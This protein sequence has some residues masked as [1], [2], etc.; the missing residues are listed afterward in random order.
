[1]KKQ[2]IRQQFA[3]TTIVLI[4]VTILICLLA[5]VLFLERVYKGDKE[6]N[7]I[8]TYQYLNENVTKGSL[9]S[10]EFLIKLENACTRYNL[11]MILLNEMNYPVITSAMNYEALSRKL[12]QYVLG[13]VPATE[14]L[15]REDKYVIVSTLDSRTNTANMEMW[16]RLDNGYIFLFSTPME[17]IRESAA[18]SSKFLCV[19]GLISIILGGMI[20]WIYSGKI[21]NPILKLAQLSEQ[22]TKLDFGAK[23]TGS[24]KNE[25]GILGNNMNSLSESLEQ[26]ISE[27][28]TANLELQQDIQKKEEI[29]LQRREFIGNV[30]HELKTPIAL[31]QG[32]A[33]GLKEGV[34]DDPES[35][36]YYLEVIGD[37]AERMNRM[38]KSLMTLSELESGSNHVVMERF[39]LVALVRNYINSADILIKEQNVKIS[40]TSPEHLYAW[41]DEFKIE[42]VVMNY[43]SN[44]IHHV[45]GEEKEIRVSIEQYGEKARVTIFNTGKHIPE[46]DLEHIWDKF[47]KVDKA[48]TRAYGGSGVGL[49]IVKAI[50]TGLQQGF[51]VDNVEG[52]VVFWFELST[53]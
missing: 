4:A 51:G 45:S 11:D 44:A 27:L 24:E 34:I 30:S 26:T 17:S 23:Y 19:I 22:I 16:G 15:V 37:E 3:V 52:G 12:L 18:L 1:M 20:A 33:E 53:L 43:F 31:I 21:S 46:E 13:L 8:E 42:E 47:Y 48:R 9:S 50:M 14:T 6:K 38:V 39:D 2:S 28:K 29:D 25:I 10:E 36:N 32:Y 7:L 5:N 40:I 49:S 41:G 35:M